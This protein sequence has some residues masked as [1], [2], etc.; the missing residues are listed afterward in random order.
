MGK[1]KCDYIL[2]TTSVPLDNNRSFEIVQQ[3]YIVCS[4]SLLSAAVTAA[5]E[6]GKCIKLSVGF[7]WPSG[8]VEEATVNKDSTSLTVKTGWSWFFL[9][10]LR[11]EP[12]FLLLFSLYKLSSTVSFTCHQNEDDDK[13]IKLI[14]LSSIVCPFP[15]AIWTQSGLAVLHCWETIMSNMR[16]NNAYKL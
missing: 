16:N 13:I 15:N 12:V 4:L 14:V 2:C 8:M 11:N 1:R 10:P 6:G 9:F 3:Y 7:S 5:T